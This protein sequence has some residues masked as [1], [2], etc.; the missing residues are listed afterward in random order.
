MLRKFYRK[1]FPAKGL[2][3]NHDSFFDD[4]LVKLFPNC[5][6]INYKDFTIEKT[7]KYKYF[8]LSGGS[9]HISD[10][11]DLVEEKE[12]IRTT[13]KPIFG[14]CL[15]FQIISLALGAKLRE[16]AEENNSK[17]QIAVPFSKKDMVVGDIEYRH[18]CY[19]DESFE[20]PKSIYTKNK[21]YKNKI[22]RQTEYKFIDSETNLPVSNLV[23]LMNGNILATQGHPEISG[24]FGKKLRDM[25]IKHYVR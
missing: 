23:L 8:V 9:I 7:K 24:D 1:F 12:F 10:K 18:H 19:I 5:D 21:F 2:I 22:H 16:F 15:G 17:S 4:D 20:F 11:N 6:I 13:H 3:I 25:F 14:I